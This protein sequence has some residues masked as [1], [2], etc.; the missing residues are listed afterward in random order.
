MSLFAAATPTVS[1]GPLVPDHIVIVVFE[2]HSYADII[3]NPSAPNF[4]AL[5]AAG[6][7]I[8]A[9]PLDPAA[10]TSGSHA[11]RHP[12]QPN[13]LELYSG[14]SQGVIQDGRPGTSAE[15]FSSPP[16]W[17]TPNLGAALR[18]AGFSFAT[19]SESLPSVG[20]DGDAATT[21]PGQNQYQRKHN[22]AANWV[23]DANPTG[24][25]LPSSVNQPFST[26]QTIGASAGGFAGLPTVS[27]VVPNEQ[28]DMHDG[29]IGQADAW[30][31]TNILDPYLTWA[32]AHNSLLI[33][34]F[35]ED[36][37]NTPTNQIPTIFAGPMVKPGNYT[38]A[39]LNLAN[40]YLVSPTE[41]G[42]QTPTFT[43]M[44]H[45]NVLS[46]LEDFYVLAHLGGSIN[47]PPVTDIFLAAP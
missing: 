7:N 15:P 22:P 21:V 18:N 44:N 46:T 32:N 29:T 20:F 43:A 12:S 40:P 31:K 34:T 35:D 14:S 30:L 39:Q 8:V 37:N 47:R 9:A 33:V 4:T 25:Y 2:N 45:F 13:Y 23:N 19:Y 10:I 26:F 5:A 38:E 24:N 28:D 42:V 1:A 41:P 17:N 6:A 36:G 3:G 27:L 11:V 16:P